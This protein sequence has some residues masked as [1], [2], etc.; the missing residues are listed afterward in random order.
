MICW[1]LRTTS[2]WLCGI[3][4]LRQ[5]LESKSFHSNPG[6]SAVY[7]GVLEHMMQKTDCFWLVLCQPAVQVWSNVGPQGLLCPEGV[8]PRNGCRSG[9]SWSV[10]WMLSRRWPVSICIITQVLKN[11][12]KRENLIEVH[13]P[14]TSHGIDQR[15]QLLDAAHELSLICWPEIV[16]DKIGNPQCSQGWETGQSTKMSRKKNNQC[17]HDCVHFSNSSIRILEAHG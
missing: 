11:T 14:E 5:N 15:Q 10:S 8:L 12:Y 16:E 4:R 13:S 7:V 6:I 3:L 17:P 2:D 1:V 9:F